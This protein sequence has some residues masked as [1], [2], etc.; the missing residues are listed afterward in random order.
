MRYEGLGAT[1]DLVGRR[2]WVTW[3]HRLD[4]LETPADVPV[5]SLRRKQRDFSYPPP[6]PGDPY[7]VYDG[8]TFPPAPVPGILEVRDLPSWETVE[9]GLRVT[10]R[11]ISVARVTGGVALEEQRRLVFTTYSQDAV[12]VAVRVELLDA[13]GLEPGVAYYYQLDDGSL[14]A[15]E[16]LAAFRAVAVAGGTHGL[17]RRLYQLLPEVYKRHDVR[18]LPPAAVL[19]GV[20]EAAGSG[21][22]LRRFL[23]VFGMGLDA[24]RSSAEG[25]AGLTDAVRVDARFLPRLARLVGWE[26]STTLEIPRQRNELLTATRLFDVVGTVPGLRALVTHQT[27]WHAQ[28]AELAQHVTRANAPAR[29]DLYAVAELPG[30][31]WRGA[32]DAAQPLGFPLAVANGA[33]G[34]PAVLASGAVE[35]FALAAGM[36]LTITVDGGVPARVRFGPDDFADIA[37]ATAAE[38]AAAIDAAFDTLAARAAAGAVELTTHATGP[39][40]SLVV[41]RTARSLLT[42]ND[43]PQGPLSAWRDAAGRLRLVYEERVPGGWD[44]QATFPAGGAAGAASPTAPPRRRILVKSWGYGE[45]RD[46]EEVPAWAGEPRSPGAAELAGGEAALAWIDAAAGGGAVAPRLRAAV[47]SSRAASPA[48]VTGLAGEPFRLVAGSQLILTGR[49]GSELF[50]VMAA[51]YA[52]P[53]N[54]TAAEVAAAMAAQLVAVTASVAGGGALRLATVTGGDRELLRVDLAQSTAAR[55]LGFGSRRLAGRGSWSPAIDWRGP[56]AGP[57]AWGP[58]ADPSPVADPLGGARLFWSEHHDGRWQLRQAHWSERLTVVTPAGAAQ[59]TGAGWQVWQ[60]A[61][62][63]PSDTVRAVVADAS[64]TL[65]F[66]TPAG[67]GSRRP[68]GTFASFTTADGLLSDDLRDLALLP[69]GTLWCA[70]PAGVAVRRPDG[71]F[72]G[73]TAAP[74]GLVADDVHAVAADGTGAAWAATPAGVSRLARGAWRSWTAAEGLPAG[75]P[76]DLALAPG[77]PA[78]LATDAG[79]AVAGGG[80]EPAGWVVH[81]VAAGLPSAD[82]RS[83]AW[84][85]DGTLA[86][87]TAAGLALWDGRRW[88]IHTTGDGLPSSD[89]RSVAPS[90]DGRLVVGTAA[91]VAIGGG[92]SWSVESVADGLPSDVVVGVHTTWSAPLV[93]AGDGG[94]HREPR[95]GVDPAGR[96]WV[97]WA[98]RPAAAAAARPVW[99]LAFRRFDPAAPAWAW[100]PPQAL[101]VAPPGGAA[102]REPSLAADGGGFRVV[103]SSDRGGGRNLWWTTVDAAG[104]PGVPQPFAAAAAEATSPV[105]VPGPDGATWVVFRSDASLAPSQAGVLQ[106]PGSGPR[107][108]VR[109]PDAGALLLRA[110]CRTPV[111]AHAARNLG[112]RHWDDLFTYTPEYPHL[113][114]AQTPTDDHLYTRRTLALYLRRARTGQPITQEQVARLKR[115]LGRF[116]PVNLRLVL[117]LS[118]EPWVELVYSE[119][120]D[121]TDAWAD[122]VPLVEVLDG[123]ADATAA[124]VPEWA[125]LL[126]NELASRSASELDLTTLRRRTWFPDLL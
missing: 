102:D 29:R 93:L 119:L 30:G 107:P 115:L 118:P 57:P 60:L 50:T 85:E 49:F 96:T 84:L 94:G 113:P 81:D 45:W 106:P 63:L 108:S 3:T 34:L 6:L 97:V 32:A 39:E 126:S 28:V 103:F 2:V 22:Q 73:H 26:P 52:D 8:A 121:L 12:A 100:E 36:E 17:N 87:A 47:G 95:A 33:P 40:A 111:L 43:A 37:A 48:I 75:T 1:A 98:T 123:L 92:S 62:G 104:V 23:D 64:G 31:G 67:L 66:A 19:P 71:T 89:L 35:P 91:G 77:R 116:L 74:G 90:P 68:D 41:E 55:A 79:V 20:P 58:P 10:V 114:A 53:A 44:E 83:L 69:D 54:A 38:V 15:G 24:L 56:L 25:L 11:G 18:T 59:T 76:R 99:T 9:D 65:W 112:R 61:D 125:V 78:A 21:G 72:T 7:L 13:A 14:P 101:T 5:V 46:A 70:T 124:A 122:S 80:G 82:V 86:A 110:G 4:A 88:R 120:A 27:G 105:S 51:D 109:V 16:E 42:P 117:I